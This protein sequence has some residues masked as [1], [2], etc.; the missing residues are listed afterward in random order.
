MYDASSPS[1]AVLAPGGTQAPA[2]GEVR[3]AFVRSGGRTRLARLYQK[4]PLRVLFPR[5]AAQ[6][7]PLAALVNV[8]GGLVAGDRALVEVTVGAGAA[9]CVTSQAA[10]KVYRAG[11]PDTVVDNRLR[12]AA[13]GWL[14][15]C[16]QE[17]ILFDRARLRRSLALDLAGDAR[18]MVGE[19][20]VL[21]RQASGERATRGLLFD[22]IDVRYDGSPAWADR[23][24]LEGD[25][26]HL[27]AAAAGLGGAV[28]VATFVHAGTGAVDRLDLARE[29]LA[30]Q[31][32][33]AATAVNGLLVARWLSTDPLALRRAFAL[34]WAGF[35]EG[36]ADLPAAMPRLWQV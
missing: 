15:W 30:D 18:A 27:L 12:V 36:A 35:R 6:D 31:E 11:G 3:L 5:H 28:A 23:L 24:R 10:E 32:D 4:A 9:A 17:T 33:A 22:R 26:A 8:G 14:E 16:P 2:A 29:L 1:E 20:V 7:L 21:G 25:F 34:F 19:L 13:G